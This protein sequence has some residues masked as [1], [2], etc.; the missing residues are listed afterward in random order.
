M[1][2][3]A[4]FELN[5]SL[6]NRSSGKRRW[7]SGESGNIRNESRLFRSGAARAL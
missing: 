4:E 3:T 7:A 1:M 6:P 2:H 5:I